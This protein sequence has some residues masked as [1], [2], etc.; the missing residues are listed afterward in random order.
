MARDHRDAVIWVL[1]ANPSRFFYE[2]LGGSAVAERQ[3]T[4][5]GTILDETGYAWPDLE[6]WLAIAG[7][8]EA[9]P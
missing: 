2:A 7:G 6:S 5:A 3:E 4:F 1:S 8:G 9:R